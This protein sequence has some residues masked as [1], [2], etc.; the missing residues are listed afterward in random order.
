MSLRQRLR[1]PWRT[2]WTHLRRPGQGWRFRVNQ[3]RSEHCESHIEL[4]VLSRSPVYARQDAEFDQALASFSQ[5]FAA[6][7]AE[8]LVGLFAEDAQALQHEE[9]TLLGQAA[10]GQMLTELFA[11]VDTAAFEVDYDIVDVHGDRAYVMAAFRETLRPKDGTAAIEVDGRL[12][13]FWHRETDGT[14]R[15]T[16]LLT[17]RASPDRLSS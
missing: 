12:V 13:C 6:G 3:N 9:P 14:W 5:A 16:R 1:R 17:S 2:Q 10:I 4:P 11:M 7:D 15:V 8:T